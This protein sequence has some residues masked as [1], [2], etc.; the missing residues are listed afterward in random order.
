LNIQDLWIQFTSKSGAVK[1]VNGAQF[2][3][4]G[5][6]TI[7]IV[8]ESGSGKSVTV[9]SIARLLSKNAEVVKGSIRFQGQNLLE[10][11]E[12]QM[13]KIRGRE[14][15]MVFQDPNSYMN[16]TIPV[17]KQV[18]EPLLYHALCSAKEAEKRAIEMLRLVGIP[19]PEQRFKEYP[20]EYSGGMLQRVLIAMAL[21]TDPVLLIA[22]EPTTALDVTVQAQILHLLKKMKDTRDMSMILVTHDLVVAAQVCDEIVVMYG[23]MVVERAPTSRFI[24]K[25][26]HPYA[27][28]LLA[29]TPRVNGAVERLKPIEGSPPDLRGELPRGCLFAPRCPFKTKQCEAERPPLTEIAPNHHVACWVDTTEVRDEVASAKAD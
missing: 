12:K 3:L 23:G 6:R 29:S 14:I 9:K 20:F 24:K 8:G 16:P 4:Q 2:S 1:A 21:I 27:I 19:S 11:S 22:D 10:L 13:R 25:H 5:G 15:S 17:G 7:G 18:M 26:R 28:G